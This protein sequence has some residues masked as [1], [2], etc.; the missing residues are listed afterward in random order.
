MGRVT[1]K[2]HSTHFFFSVYRIKLFTLLNFE[3]AFVRFAKS[4]RGIDSV[5]PYNFILCTRMA[6]EIRRP[7]CYRKVINL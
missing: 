1:R 7:L 3:K 5:L 6:C 2:I 4:L